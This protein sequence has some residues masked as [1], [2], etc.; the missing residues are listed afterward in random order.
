M[1]DT[2][3]PH[4]CNISEPCTPALGSFPKEHQPQRIRRRRC[5]G[6]SDE[7]LASSIPT[8]H[9]IRGNSK[10]IWRRQEAFHWGYLETIVHV[11]TYIYICNCIICSVIYYV[12]IYIYTCVCV[13]VCVCVC[14]VTPYVY[15]YIHII[16][17]SLILYNCCHSCIRVWTLRQ[18][19]F[20]SFFGP[21]WEIEEVKPRKTKYGNTSHWPS[22]IIICSVSKI[23]KK[24]LRHVK[25]RSPDSCTF[26]PP[27]FGDKN[28]SGYIPTSGVSQFLPETNIC[29]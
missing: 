14:L 15:I 20:L 11:Y 1:R 19:V 4:A 3:S 18:A 7:W 23:K 25:L 21:R 28:L 10:L 6:G 24:N 26:Q 12:C 27:N 29:T 22:L 17:Y 13:F 16:V 9:W 8:W 2:E 5:A